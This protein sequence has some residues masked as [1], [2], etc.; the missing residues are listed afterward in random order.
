M[1]DAN[2]LPRLSLTLDDAAEAT[3]LS[4]T[5]LFEAVREK[6]LT[7]RK[8]GKATIVEID[9]MRRYIRSLPTKGRQLEQVPGLT[10]SLPLT[11]GA[12]T[13]RLGQGANI[14]ASDADGPCWE[15]QRGGPQ[16]SQQSTNAAQRGRRQPKGHGL[17][18]TAGP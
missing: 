8:D 13:A 3:G 2:P 1:D 15:P 10:E 6:K 4:R 18:Q 14:R 16:T 9:E 7:V 17:T 11:A 12:K 5:R